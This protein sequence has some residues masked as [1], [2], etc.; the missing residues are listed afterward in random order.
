[1]ICRLVLMIINST[2][3]IKKLITSMG[4][5]KVVF[6]CG[7]GFLVALLLFSSSAAAAAD[8]NDQVVTIDVHAAAK[9]LLHHHHPLHLY[10]DVRTQEEFKNGQLENSFNI[11]YMLN[12]S[13]GMVKNPIFVDQVLSLCAKEDHLIV[14]CKSGV[15]SFYATTDLLN[16]GFKHVYNMG[17]GYIAW[18]Q[19]GYDVKKP[20]TDEL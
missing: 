9:L 6:H 12:T 15:R 4:A 7:I 17:G 14:G 16:S 3:E 11:P 5:F 19:N 10:L 8:D 13:Q 1:M 18:T 20:H 2:L